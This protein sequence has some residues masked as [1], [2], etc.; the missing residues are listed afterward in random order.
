MLVTLILSL[1]VLTLLAMP[2]TWGRV[3][4]VGA[5]L[6]GCA[7]L[8]PVAAVRGFYA[9]DLPR[10]QLAGTLLIAAA[11]VAALAVFWALSRRTAGT[12]HE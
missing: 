10:G 6:A 1:T 8:F 4:L 3:I 9:L 5:A 7:L 2:L 11:G 12:A